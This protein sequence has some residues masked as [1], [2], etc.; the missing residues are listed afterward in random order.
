M[1]R[2]PRS[3][4]PSG[5]PATLDRFV[6]LCIPE[7]DCDH[8]KR[9]G[10]QIIDRAS[11]DAAIALRV[12]STETDLRGELPKI[13]QP[14]LVIHGDA[15][16]VVPIDRGHEL[17]AALPNARLVVLPGAGHVPTLT[18]PADVARVIEDFLLNRP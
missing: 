2:R 9:W 14:T 4:R 13:G 16:V 12:V 18:R 10:R 5:N 8:L 1:A 15:D 7:P 3:A 17:A 11:Q 6:Q